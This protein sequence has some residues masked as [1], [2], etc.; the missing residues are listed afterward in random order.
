MTVCRAAFAEHG[1]RPGTNRAR[2]CEVPPGEARR[3]Q[4]QRP[5]PHARGVRCNWLQQFGEPTVTRDEW[6]LE[7][8]STKGEVL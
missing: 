7:H 8:G 4:Q 2:A 5:R 1:G 6:R 3:P